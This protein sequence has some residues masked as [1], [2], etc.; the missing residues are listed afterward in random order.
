MSPVSP[1][2]SDSDIGSDRSVHSIRTT[3]LSAR[4]ITMA[5]LDHSGCQRFLHWQS[6]IMYTLYFVFLASHRFV[7]LALP[8]S[9]ANQSS[10][11][12]RRTSI[13]VVY[14]V[15]ALD[16]VRLVWSRDK[17][18]GVRHHGHYNRSQVFFP[19]SSP[20]SPSSHRLP[21]TTSFVLRSSFF[22]TNST[23]LRHWNGGRCTQCSIMGDEGICGK[24]EEG[25]GLAHRVP[26]TRTVV[27]GADEGAI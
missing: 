16:F 27:V 24:L 12:H 26:E 17:E 7:V 23:H 19:S 25:T 5:F 13:V 11:R 22:A 3:V 14:R 10:L 21:T 15:I 18:T 9:L 20:S 2:D 6:V 8:L 1:L 4:C